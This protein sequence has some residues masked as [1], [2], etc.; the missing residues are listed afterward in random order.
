MNNGPRILVVEDDGI[1]AEDISSSLG[2]LGYRDIAIAHSG[3]SAIGCAIERRP[4]LVLMDIKLKGKMD[5]IEAAHQIRDRFQVPVVYLT[6]HA[7][8]KT[9][10][11]AKVTEPFGYLLKPYEAHELR[12]TIEMALHKGH[13]EER[14]RQKE[15]LLLSTLRD[16]GDGVIATDAN[17][18]VTFIN[19]AAE[20]MTEFTAEEALGKSVDDVFRVVHAQTGTP[21]VSP[22]S[23]ALRGR[24]VDF[25][26][27][28]LLHAK[29]GRAIAIGDRAAPIRGLK[30]EITGAVLVFHDATGRK[31]MEER[32]RHSQKMEAVGRL[33]G[34]V[35]HDFGN[36]LNVIAAQAAL[37]Q[38]FPADGVIRKRAAEIQKAAGKAISLTRQLLAV[39]RKP[40]F[41]L[42]VFDLRDL[43]TDMQDLL[44]SIV[45]TRIHLR[46]V[47]ANEPCLIRADPDQIQ[48]VLMN[49]VQNARD[50]ISAAGALIVEIGNVNLR[51][52]V[53]SQ[54]MTVLP[55]NYVTL[56][57]IDNGSGMD[58]NTIEHMFEPFFTTKEKGKGTGLGLAAV[59]EVL[60]LCDA[61]IMV[62]SAPG[63][64][65]KLTMY[66][67][68]HKDETAAPQ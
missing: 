34:Q 31:Y 44:L 5:G 16:M 33:A 66:F 49:L 6:A 48:Q 9:V 51:E 11:R 27:N 45:T 28:T 14:R 60:R 50:A 61:G 39:S 36:I 55:G 13:M 30:G 67:P 47:T 40:V 37:I 63:L 32:L 35:A 42:E 18:L 59:Y 17:G 12:T 68:R 56:A 1:I 46:L 57:I 22:V 29:R 21:V 4:D 19:P 25:D 2:R 64:G 52:A 3:E 23:E 65:T 62:E 41:K 26:R 58:A 20:Q 38:S 7:D 43:T 24:A 8:D 15:R 54:S 53:I 10:E